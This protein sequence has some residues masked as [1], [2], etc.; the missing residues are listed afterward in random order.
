MEY[1][2]DEVLLK[3]KTNTGVSFVEILTDCLKH[4]RWFVLS[5]ALCLL[6]GAILYLTTEK[7]YTTTSAVLLNLDKN[8]NGSFTD[9][10]LEL[11]GFTPTS[12]M[13]NEIAIFSSRNLMF[14]VV[15]SLHLRN[16]Y[17]TK[18]LFRREEIFDENPFTATFEN[19]DKI[20][21]L[22]FFVKRSG[23]VYVVSG[24]YVE[25]REE[26]DFE[27]EI[28]EFPSEILFENGAILTLSA[29]DTPFDEGKKYFVDIN[30]SRERTATALCRQLHVEAISKNASVLNLTFKG[31]HALKNAAILD[32]IVRQYNAMNVR[33]KN[34]IAYNTSLFINERLRDIAVELGDTED[35]IV[36]FKQEHNITNID[37]EAKIFMEQGSDDDKRLLEIETQLNI[38]QDI[39]KYINNPQNKNKVVPNIG[40]T[41]V[42]LSQI[43]NTYNTTLLASEMQIQQLTPESPTYKRIVENNE[44]MRNSI[45]ASMQTLQRT[46]RLTKQDLQ[47]QIARTRAKITSVPKQEMGLLGK[48]RDQQ[49]KQTLF[50]FLMQKREENNLTIAATP[51][52]AMVVESPLVNL[53]PSAPRRIVFGGVFLILGLIIPF[54]TIYILNLIRTQIRSRQE[55]EK[56]TQIAIAGQ[57]AE[58]KDDKKIVIEKGKTTPIAEML[59]SLRNNLNFIF[60]NESH[61]TILLTS[62]AQ[63]EGKTFISANLAMSYAI[64]DKKA[65]LIGGDIRNPKL[66][67]Y[68]TPD[69]EGGLTNYLADEKKSW[70]SLITVSKENENLHIL[71]AGT[72]PPNPNELLMSEKLKT[73]LEEAQKEYDFVIID[74]APVGLVSDTYLI[75]ADLTLYVLRGGVTQ[76]SSIAFVNNLKEEDKLQHIYLLLNAMEQGKDYGYK[77]KYKYGNYYSE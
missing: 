36:N 2:E 42:G 24:S 8:G 26:K 48:M 51:N 23:N 1:Y 11:L 10:N 17:Y 32:E 39:E 5:L 7:E 76:K 50:L 53:P 58:N 19:A 22:T 66:K 16:V 64:A 29:T 9:M 72:I 62:T 75:P 74:S 59:R 4:W 27:K 6:V 33:I 52:K 20:S 37:T 45:S 15:D 25:K 12:N 30:S 41:D 49:V 71:F 34:E 63:G 14:G 60:K 55:V 70:K 54:L 47:R 67:N 40:I 65:L 77:Y 56:M 28:D 3:E 73:L 13:D 69:K 46:Y 61:K 31:N 18:K 21:T 38:L 68:F 57:V 43:I 44:N 35:K